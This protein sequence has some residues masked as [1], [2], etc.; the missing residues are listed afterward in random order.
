MHTRRRSGGVCIGGVSDGVA[1]AVIVVVMAE[2]IMEG[3]ATAGVV[4]VE[5]HGR[6]WR[7]EAARK[8]REHRAGKGEWRRRPRTTA[9]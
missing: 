3:V 1:V 6:G 5:G 2:A 4:R 7:K 8:M 9:R